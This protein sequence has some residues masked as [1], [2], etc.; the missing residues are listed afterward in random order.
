MS[1]INKES[2]RKESQGFH[3]V[4]ILKID[5]I[6]IACSNQE[7]GNIYLNSFETEP[8]I[9]EIYERRTRRDSPGHGQG[10]RTIKP[11]H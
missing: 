1:F 9:S 8:A 7:T 2:K 3:K 6:A 10:M 4:L 11:R 5:V